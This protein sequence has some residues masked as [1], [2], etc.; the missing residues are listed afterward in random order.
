MADVSRRLLGRDGVAETSAAAS[1]LVAGRR[2]VV[3][4]A[5]GSIGSE[6]VRQMNRLGAHVYLL[7]HD[8]ER[9][10]RASPRGE[11]VELLVDLVE[12]DLDAPNHSP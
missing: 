2:V 4:G 9:V 11:V 12:H 8:G 5:A 7:D 10:L 1:A 3:T 6:L